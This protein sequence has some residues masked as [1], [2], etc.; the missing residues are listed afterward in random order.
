LIRLFA[1]TLMAFATVPVFGFTVALTSKVWVVKEGR[2]S[3]GKPISILEEPSELMAGNILIFD[4]RATNN[5]TEPEANI[6]VT[7]PVP[8]AVSFL[9]ATESPMLSVDGGKN[10]GQLETLSVKMPDGRQRL[11]QLDDVTHVKW[12]IAGPVPVGGV[13]RLSYR[14]RVRDQFGR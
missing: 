11:A 7:N 3:A 13:V 12:Q 6:T 8:R 5:S 10:W 1:I 2:N 4:I 14:G 9:S